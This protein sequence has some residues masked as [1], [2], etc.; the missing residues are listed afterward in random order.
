MRRLARQGGLNAKTL[1]PGFLPAAKANPQAW[2]YPCPR[3]AFDHCWRYL[4]NKS[5]TLHSLALRFRQLY[6]SI[7]WMDMKPS[8]PDDPV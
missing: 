5:T 4:T 6:A 7:R 1:A 2:P 8:D 3:P